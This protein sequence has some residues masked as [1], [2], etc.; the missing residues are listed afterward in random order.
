MSGGTT[1]A[2]SNGAF[3][4]GNVS[5]TAGSVTLTLQGGTNPNYIADFANLSIFDMTDAVNLNYTGTE[6]VQQ[7]IVNGVQQAAGV[8][9]AGDLPELFGT[10]TLTVIGIPE[11]AT[12]MLMGIGLLLGAQRLR[13]RS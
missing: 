13:R 10:G 11:P 7:L 2:T 3:G 8:Y 6:T 5:L 9:G 4:S 1:I 12:W